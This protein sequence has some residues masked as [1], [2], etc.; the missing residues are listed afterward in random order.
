MAD[1]PDKITK[2]IIDDLFFNLETIDAQSAAVLR[3]LK[4]KGIAPDKDFAPYL[5]QASDAASVR[6]L[7]T[8]VRL[9]RLLSDVISDVEQTA[10]EVTEKAVEQKEHARPKDEAA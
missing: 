10:E 2:E 1:N 7:A 6:W 9:E 4:E 5:Q 8:R 3:F